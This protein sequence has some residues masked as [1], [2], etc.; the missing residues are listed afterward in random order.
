MSN[1]VLAKGQAKQNGTSLFIITNEAG[2]YILQVGPFFFPQPGLT[3]VD[4]L[5][6]FTFF[7]KIKKKDPL[8]LTLPLK[9]DKLGQTT[10]HPS[11]VII[12]KL[13]PFCFA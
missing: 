6:P 12:N 9:Q 11:F 5:S 8:L 1:F 7:S 13:V 3:R 10:L 4:F 2:M